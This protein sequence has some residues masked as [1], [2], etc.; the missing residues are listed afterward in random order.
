MFFT[1]TILASLFLATLLIGCKKAEAPPTPKLEGA[2]G[3]VALPASSLPA[4]DG[5]LPDQPATGTS[6]SGNAYGSTQ[7]DS[8]ELTKEQESAAMPLSGQANNHSTPNP[9]EQKK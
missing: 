5:K 2:T 3:S 1:R 7:A 6:D 9:A 8:K 4:S